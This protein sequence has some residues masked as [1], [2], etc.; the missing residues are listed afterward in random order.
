[1]DLTSLVYSAVSIIITACFLVLCA[2]VAIIKNI[3]KSRHGHEYWKNEFKKHQFLGNSK[4]AIEAYWEMI[5]IDVKQIQDENA[6]TETRVK[7]YEE[8]KLKYINLEKLGGSW[9]VGYFES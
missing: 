6:D 2:N 1:M 5:W 7:K 9:P 8:L 3:L 4:K